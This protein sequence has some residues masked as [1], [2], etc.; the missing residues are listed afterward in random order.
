ME[1][2]IGISVKGH[3]SS[4]SD[5]RILLKTRHR[6]VDVIETAS[7]YFWSTLRTHQSRG[8]RQMFLSWSRSMLPKTWL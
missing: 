1:E 4:L 8:I 6:L 5:P 2:A 3:F 7:G